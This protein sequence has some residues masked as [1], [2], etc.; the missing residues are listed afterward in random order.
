MWHPSEFE[1]AHENASGRQRLAPCPAPSV[2]TNQVV[3]PCTTN[4]RRGLPI[5]NSA[6]PQS[7][8]AASRPGGASFHALRPPT[9]HQA[10]G[11]LPRRP[12]ESTRN[13]DATAGHIELFRY[14]WVFTE[15]ASTT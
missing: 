10:G 6:V 4:V 5:G 7:P 8:P 15:N 3:E 13:A 12:P 14:G 1:T 11:K 2:R 9:P